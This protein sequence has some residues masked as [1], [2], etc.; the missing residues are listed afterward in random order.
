MALPYSDA[1]REAFV[2]AI[3]IPPANVTARRTQA[4][5]ADDDLPTEADRA[6]FERDDDRIE[7]DRYADQ[8]HDEDILGM[9]D[10]DLPTEEDRE[11]HERDEELDEREEEQR[12]HE[13]SEFDEG[14]EQWAA[15]QSDEDSYDPRMDPTLSDDE[16]LG[17]LSPRGLAEQVNERT[18]AYDSALAGPEWKT[19]DLW[20][21]E[22]TDNLHDLA[23]L[24][25]E[26][27]HNEAFHR[28]MNPEN[29]AQDTE[30]LA[31]LTPESLAS[32]M[33]LRQEFI[34]ENN[35]IDAPTRE[36]A[37]Q[38]LDRARDM[39]ARR[40]Q[41]QRQEWAEY[42][43]VMPGVIDAADYE[44]TAD[45]EYL[46][47]LSE[48]DIGVEMSERSAEHRNAVADAQE[49]FIEGHSSERIDLA[50]GRLERA[51]NVVRHQRVAQDSRSSAMDGLA[52]R[53]ETI[54]QPQNARKQAAESPATAAP[55]TTKYRSPAAFDEKIDAAVRSRSAGDIQT[56][57]DRRRSSPAKSEAKPPKSAAEDK[58]A[59]A[60]MGRLELADTIASRGA[61]LAASRREGQPDNVRLAKQHYFERA[62]GES[63]ARDRHQADVAKMWMRGAVQAH[64]SGEKP[65]ILPDR[66]ADSAALAKMSDKDLAREVG[67]RARAADVANAA[68]SPDREA[69]NAAFMAAAD[70]VV[71]R[72]QAQVAE[73]REER[74]AGLEPTAVDLPVV[75]ESAPGK[76]DADSISPR[77]PVRSPLCDAM[78]AAE[79]QAATQPQVANHDEPTMS[80]K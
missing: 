65:N 34:S 12:A 9:A 76:V 36:A 75:A 24:A 51:E 47:G 60:G 7:D 40:E 48:A 35:D 66:Q 11:R 43:G 69:A 77:E 67:L 50:R 61:A 2:R 32:E 15:G 44:A 5:V 45:R 10:D 59:L 57:I 52:A 4:V 64:M 27:A 29:T 55:A 33:R 80:A 62:V 79:R 26:R 23:E 38:A 8:Q 19:V 72:A 18:E 25:L 54:G 1:A 53:L 16:F 73:W 20:P 28:A 71:G 37:T 6:R 56:A 46:E 41:V 58:R 74:R 31:A 30:Y 13:D 17:L 22:R 68:G 39:S 42:G 63:M 78:D 3:N 70:Q 49:I 21:G 14:A